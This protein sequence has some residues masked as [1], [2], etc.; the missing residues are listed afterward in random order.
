MRKEG[1]KVRAV[2]RTPARAQALV[3]LGYSPWAAAE[4]RDDHVLRKKLSTAK[5]EGSASFAAVTAQWDIEDNDFFLVRGQYL[6]I[7]TTGTQTQAFYDGTGD[8]FTGINDKI[9]S[10]QTSLSFLFSH[11]F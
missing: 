8:V 2:V 7:D 11:R 10:Q 1:L 6:K 3:D 9:T 5:T 4:D